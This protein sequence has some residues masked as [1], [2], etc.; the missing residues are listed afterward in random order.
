[1]GSSIRAL[2]VVLATFLTLSL[3]L[4]NGCFGNRITLETNASA[5]QT[6]TEVRK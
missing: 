4:W 1:M 6:L 2:L 3:A 5:A